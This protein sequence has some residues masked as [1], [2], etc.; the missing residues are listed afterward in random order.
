QSTGAGDTFIAALTLAIAAGADPK[1]AAR[2]AA[3]A[4]HLVVQQLGTNTCNF[5]LLRQSLSQIPK[6]LHRNSLEAIVNHHR[7]QGQQIVFT[8]G[9]FDLLHPGHVTYLAQARALGD[10]LMVGVNSDRSVQGL[11]GPTRPIN[12]LEDRLAVLAALESVTYVIPFDE[13]TPRELIKI[14]RP[15]IFAKGGD[16]TPETLAEAPLVTQLGGVIKILPFLGDRSTTSII[17]RIQALE[18]NPS[19][20]K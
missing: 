9:C 15:D 18:R 10:I 13:S 20:P 1:A 16:Y 6:I 3:T 19:S 14:V 7:H 5:A 8:N 11:K 4:S 2:I 12:P 17:K